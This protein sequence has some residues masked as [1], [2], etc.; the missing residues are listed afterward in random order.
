VGSDFSRGSTARRV[1][2]GTGANTTFGRKGLSVPQT[3]A[4]WRR[5]GARRPIASSSG[6]PITVVDENGVGVGDIDVA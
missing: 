4:N 5:Y 6:V 3:G 1:C 2:S